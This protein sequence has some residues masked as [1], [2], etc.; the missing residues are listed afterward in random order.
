M[1]ICIYRILLTNAQFSFYHDLCSLNLNLD[2]D[3]DT[4]SIGDY[5]M[6][7]YKLHHATSL[8]VPI[9]IKSTSMRLDYAMH[10]NENEKCILFNNNSKTP[11]SQSV[12]C[13]K[14]IKI[15]DLTT[16]DVDYNVYQLFIITEVENIILSKP[17]PFTKMISASATARASATEG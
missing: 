2:I 5:L 11:N 3:H 8:N 4:F 15:E 10:I 9:Y 17:N 7:N 12:N 16:Y 13:S 1:L 14:G 6:I